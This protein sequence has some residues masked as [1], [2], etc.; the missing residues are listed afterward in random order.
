MIMVTRHACHVTG[1]GGGGGGGGGWSGS[2][3]A[4]TRF[5]FAFYNSNS[6]FK[7]LRNRHVSLNILH[8]SQQGFTAIT[9][10]SGIY[11]KCRNRE[12]L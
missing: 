1:G 3:H 10:I 9:G 4:V 2:F 5:N 7:V 11:K 12:K 8:S 6:V